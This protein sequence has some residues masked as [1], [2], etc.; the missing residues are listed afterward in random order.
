[1]RS[2]DDNRSST[3]RADG[4]TVACRVP[5]TQ[6][7]RGQHAVVDCSTLTHLP[8]EDRCMLRALGLYDRCTVRV[9]RPGRPCIV[10]IDATRL[11]LSAAMAQQILVE[12]CDDPAEAE[13]P[14]EPRLA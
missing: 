12:P 5:L 3:L 7:A 13:R 9:C 1:M 14:G 4:C 10:Q 11:G 8:E 2:I 6:L